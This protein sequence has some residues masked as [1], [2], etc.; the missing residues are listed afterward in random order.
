MKM[1]R[2]LLV[3]GTILTI[4]ALFTLTG[5]DNGGGGE[6]ENAPAAGATQNTVA[7]GEVALTTDFPPEQIE[8]TPM[9]VKLPN[10]VQA[11]KQAPT[12]G[13]P[14]G[15]ELVSQGKP[16]TSSDD[17]PVI[18]EISYITDGEKLGGEGY[19]VEFIGGVPQWIQIDLEQ[20]MPIEAV[21]LWH[22]HSQARAYHDVIVQVSN[23]P[24]FEEGVTTVFNNDYDESAGM[25]VGE[26]NPYVESRYGKLIDVDGVEGRYVRCY[27]TG[28]TSS[29]SIHYIEVEVYGRPGAGEA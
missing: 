24:N 19:Y 28:N 6:E 10:L 25:G 27:A 16:V 13:V 26:D 14:E 9:P 4:G 23:D 22:F 11:P 12:T 3:S 1:T 18:G 15:T 7:E 17:Y 20:T 5:C 8:G 2:K 29:D 21:W